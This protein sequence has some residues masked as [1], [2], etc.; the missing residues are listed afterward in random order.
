LS[1]KSIVFP[2]FLKIF[3]FK[4]KNINRYFVQTSLFSTK[5][6]AKYGFYVTILKD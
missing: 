3:L 4:I 1:K 6:L 5:K 2:E